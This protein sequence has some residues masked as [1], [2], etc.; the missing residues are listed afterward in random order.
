MLP[1]IDE[2]LARH[3]AGMLP[4][5]ERLYLQL[6]EA[7]PHNP[8]LFHLLGVVAY[9]TGRKELAAERIARAV[10]LKP[11]F[12]EAH[13]NL[14]NALK[15][16]GRIDAAMASY[17]RA[18]ALKPDFADP[19]FNLGNV[20]HE[21]GRKDEAVVCYRE[22]IRL[23]PDYVDAISNLA[24][25]LRD[26]DHTDEAVNL[27]HRA[28]GLR[29][30]HAD[31]LSNLGLILL[32]QERFSE[33]VTILR[34]TLAA[35]PRHVRASANLGLALEGLGETEE[36]AACHERAMALDPN[37]VEPLPNLSHLRRKM[38]R[39][40][41]FAEDDAKLLDAV[42]SRRFRIA[43]FMVLHAAG[44]TAADHLGAARRWAS[45]IAPPRG[46]A[47]RHRPGP[48]KPRIHVG[49]L[50]ADLHCHPVGFLL[51]ELIERHD[52]ARFTVSAYSYGED[53]SSPMR[54][55]LETAFDQ[56]VHIRDLDNA[57]AATR[58]RDDGVDILVDLTGYT[59]GART[60]ILA[61]RPSPIQANYLGFAG[62]MGADFVD[63]IIADPAIAPMDQQ[64]CFHER[65]VHL[66]GSYLPFDTRRA[67]AERTPSR[68]ECGLPEDGL[69]FCCFHNS[70]KITPPFF[71]AWM[72]LLK[73]LPGSVLWLLDSAKTT[74]D[75]LR[76][77][78]VARGVDP[79]RLVFSQ[80]LEVGDYLVRH[81]L[82]D[83][84][85]DVL[86]YNAHGS[87]M[88]ALWMGLP[89]LT[90]S[91]PT[92]PGRVAGRLLE[93]LG[94]DELVT[95]SL[96]DYEATAL[97]L[98]RDPA[99]LAGLRQRLAAA[100]DTSAL[101]DMNAFTRQLEAAYERMWETWSQGCPPEGFAV[102]PWGPSPA[103]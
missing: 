79:E 83:L 52:R 26:L 90:C 56:F 74:A 44:A 14:G 12:A 46:Q 67:V 38:C 45:E 36:A 23:R 66:P 6:L 57:T 96:A 7:E 80:R 51:G 54:R 93:C 27:L 25:C 60:A 11:D 98:A 24:M 39:W 15:D 55:R 5:A 3:R 88:D 10:A 75:N 92:F 70:F 29:P 4:E 64:G 99:R 1:T 72:R 31:A 78:A 16:L 101:F 103:P 50:S 43:P 18:T 49:Y 47:F 35:H 89:V 94:L 21:L 62:S 82:A 2:V 37:F 30:D 81:R 85:L 77:E 86:P 19:H 91:G 71:D 41:R 59:S 73:A 42:R 40:E 69:V 34:R 13:S 9:Q 48:P 95:R 102:S 100:R 76:R 84:Y 33:A 68:A 20:L 63:Y 87:A 22:A 65:I 61:A 8:L 97:D 28:I 17:G 53:D 58:I 32:K